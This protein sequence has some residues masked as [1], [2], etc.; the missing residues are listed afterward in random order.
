[1]K[2]HGDQIFNEEDA[3]YLLEKKLD[4]VNASSEGV[5]EHDVWTKQILHI[6]AMNQ[7]TANTL[8]VV[9][10]KLKEENPML[11][12]N[13]VMFITITNAANPELDTVRRKRKR[14]RTKAD[15]YKLWGRCDWI[16]FNIFT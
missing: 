14:Q 10:N 3:R 7:A 16:Y 5:L 15:Y 6:F 8:H 11:V 13:T 9:Y 4:S 1:M 12:S 2:C